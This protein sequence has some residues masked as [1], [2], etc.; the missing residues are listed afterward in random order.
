MPAL[1]TD[2]PRVGHAPRLGELLLEMGF[3]DRFQLETA[4]DQ[5]RHTGQRLGAILVER[6]LVT[7]SR[8]VRALARQLNL[9]TVDPVS[10]P[11]SERVL[12]MLPRELA[13]ALRVVP[14]AMRRTPSGPVF[15]VATADPMAPHVA[16]DLQHQVG[17]GI[18]MLLCGETEVELALARHYGRSAPPVFTR[19]SPSVS[20]TGLSV[21]AGQPEE[22]IELEELVPEPEE[23]M[24]LVDAIHQVAALEPL[25]PQPTRARG[26]SASPFGPDNDFPRLAA[27]GI[28]AMD[29]LAGRAPTAADILPSGFLDPVQS[30]F[31]PP[32]AAPKFELP[33]LARAS[34]ELP[35]AEEA[36]V[37]SVDLTLPSAP[38]LTLPSEWAGDSFSELASVQTTSGQQNWGDLVPTTRSSTPPALPRQTAST[39]AE[40]GIAPP[41]AFAKEELSLGFEIDVSEVTEVEPEP[42]GTRLVHEEVDLADDPNHALTQPLVPPSNPAPMPTM[43]VTGSLPVT[44]IPIHRPT[45]DVA[46]ARALLGRLLEGAELRPDEIH[47]VL[48]LF[49]FGLTETWGEDRI[50]DAIS[51]IG[52]PPK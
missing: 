30:E 25:G 28:G 29:A 45:Q 50:K 20:V 38:P 19:A 27:T 1:G 32:Q 51:R 2:P 4:L 40:L 31:P 5:Q 48:R 18:E 47:W 26:A 14:I 9:Q 52:P 24:A 49:A 21:V 10:S 36:M 12:A 35:D 17:M 8:L 6:G 3:I 42:P 11:V 15:C 46:Q 39:P 16:E 34:V 41:T 37:D 43:L 23:R 22:P 44:S 13:V 33:E 7:E